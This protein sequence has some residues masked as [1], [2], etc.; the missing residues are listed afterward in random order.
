MISVARAI[1]IVLSHVR[2]APAECIPLLQAMH[3]V[4]AENIFSDIDLPPFDKASM[5]GYAFRSAATASVPVNLRVVGTIAAGV[6]PRFEIGSGQAAKIMTGAPLPA[7]ADCVQMV[8][9]TESES[10]EQV[11]ILEAVVPGQHVAKQGEV[12]RADTCVLKAG[13]Y[14]SPQT[15]A[16]LATVGHEEVSTY[17][18]PRVGILVTGD[19]L[20]DVSENPGPGQIRNSNAAALFAQVRETGAQAIPLGIASDDLQELASKIREG[21]A[22]D[23]LLMTGGVSMGEFDFVEQVLTEIG[24]EIFFK[25]VNIKPGKPA[26]FAKVGETLIFGLPGNPVSA[27]TV[28]EVIARPALRKM[29]GFTQFGNVKVEA[30]LTEAFKSKTRREN[31]LPGQAAWRDGTFLVRPVVSKG[32][33]D[34]RAHALSNCYLL[35][36]PETDNFEPGLQIEVMLRSDFWCGN[37]FEGEF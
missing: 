9:K 35:A 34:V 27:S 6:F 13:S 1:E 29:M 23:M 24:A 3:R 17:K 20:V 31:Y 25:K 11:Q 21:L 8:E 36:P 10:A 15:L 16:L 28:F 22:N 14:V 33:A 32:S 30:K 26:V 18:R 19:E 5:D 2:V 37:G 7:G 4:L 12:L